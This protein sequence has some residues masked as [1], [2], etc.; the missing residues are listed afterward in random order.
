VIS[1][2][3]LAFGKSFRNADIGRAQ[4]EHAGEGPDQGP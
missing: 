2:V 4:E 3:V 1:L